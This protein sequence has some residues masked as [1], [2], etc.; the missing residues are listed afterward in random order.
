MSSPSARPQALVACGCI[1]ASASVS[2]D[3][4]SA[5]ELEVG[6]ASA[7]RHRVAVAQS[8]RMNAVS[9]TVPLLI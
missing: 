9:R 2:Y 8:E 5:T 4:L 7:E 3:L 6:S 1:A